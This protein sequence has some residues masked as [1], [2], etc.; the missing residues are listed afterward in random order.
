[1]DVRKLMCKACGHMF[2]DEL[3][4]VCQYGHGDNLTEYAICPECGHMQR[5]HPVEVMITSMGEVS[6]V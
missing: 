5:I 2:T 4:D 6:H 3:V 1:M